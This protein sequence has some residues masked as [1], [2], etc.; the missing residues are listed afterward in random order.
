MVLCG[1]FVER[2][3]SLLRA[4]ATFAVSGVLTGRTILGAV[5][6]SFSLGAAD[7]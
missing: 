2:P 5:Y 7:E 6:M 3:L 4:P 1:D